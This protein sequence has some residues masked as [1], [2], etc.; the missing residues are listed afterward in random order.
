MKKITLAGLKK[1]LTYLPL[2]AHDPHV[3]PIKLLAYSL[4]GGAGK[5][6]PFNE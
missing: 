4:S 3:N 6:P 2:S 5:R 1:L